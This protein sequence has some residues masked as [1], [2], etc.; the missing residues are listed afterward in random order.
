MHAWIE[1]DP[2]DVVDAEL[3]EI[4]YNPFMGPTFTIRP[5]FVPVYVAQ[6][7][8]PEVDGRVWATL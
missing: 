3:V 1:G 6:L 2:R 4:G 8:V 5:G 7:V